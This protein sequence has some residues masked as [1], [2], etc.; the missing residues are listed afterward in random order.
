MT[1]QTNVIEAKGL[2]SEEVQFAIQSALWAKNTIRAERQERI[3]K[4]L[5]RTIENDR[6][7]AN[8]LYKCIVE[9]HPDIAN[10]V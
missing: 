8:I 3:A 6:D 7:F 1:A 9:A 10:N 5:L 4:L 2:N